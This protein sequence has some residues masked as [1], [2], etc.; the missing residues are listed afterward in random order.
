VPGT[1]RTALGHCAP[2]RAEGTA[3]RAGTPR[4]GHAG[5]P[6]QA[7]T[8][9]GRTGPPRWQAAPSRRAS[10]PQVT[11]RAPLPPRR[12]VRPRR[13]SFGRTRQPHA[14]KAEGTPGRAPG[15]ARR[16]HGEEGAGGLGEEGMREGRWREVGEKGL[17]AGGSARARRGRRR[18]RHGGWRRPP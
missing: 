16:E 11:G 5:P 18:E 15:R 17:V 14:R 4:A 2:R 7:A 6:R 9:E 8:Q 10:A 13:V 1:A 3:R 12:V